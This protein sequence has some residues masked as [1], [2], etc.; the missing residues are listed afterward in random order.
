MGREK[1]TVVLRIEVSV[2][3]GS[4]GKIDPVK[5]DRLAMAAT[6]LRNSGK[7]VLMVSSGAIVLGSEMLEYDTIPE[8]RLGMQV[9]AAVGQAGL[10][11]SYQSYFDEYNQIIAQVLITSDIINYSQRMDN[12]SNTFRALLSMNI[13]PVVNENDPVS[14]TDIDLNDNYPLAII[15]A[16]IAGADIIVVKKESDGQY[17]IIPGDD[18][19]PHLVNS[20]AA[21]L[22]DIDSVYKDQVENYSTSQKI[23]PRALKDIY[24]TA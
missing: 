19:Q 24:V 5:M 17:L 2:L 12:A 18:L 4:D 9:A 22:A 6:N 14:T 3:L 21:L 13:I 1:L 15:V 11:R 8:T 23:F 16:G 10:I 20:E 7:N